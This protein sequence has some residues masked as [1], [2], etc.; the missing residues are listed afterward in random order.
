[1]VLWPGTGEV[2]ARTIHGRVKYLHGNEHL[3][4][5][6]STR[7]L[8]LCQA[9]GTSFEEAKFKEL[10]WSFLPSLL[11]LLLPL[12]VE[13]SPRGATRP[14]GLQDLDGCGGEYC[15]TSGSECHRALVA[16]RC[17][18]GISLRAGLGSGWWPPRL[19]LQWLF[20]SMASL[21]SGS[22]LSSPG[23]SVGLLMW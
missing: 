8:I 5:K 11:R 14:A 1:M 3:K 10:S 21:R 22:L 20:C 17:K 4:G 23:G 9:R 19:S 6:P 15:S 16:P 13:V 2:I 7:F 12:V 18:G